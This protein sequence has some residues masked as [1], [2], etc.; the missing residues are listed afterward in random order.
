MSA[1]FPIPGL[2][3]RKIFKN[4]GYNVIIIDNDIINKVLSCESHYTLDVVM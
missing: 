2:L 3:K 4:K 1:K